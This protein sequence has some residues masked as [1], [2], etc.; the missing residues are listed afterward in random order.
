MKILNFGSCNIDLVY[1]VDHIALPGET[2]GSSS[3]ELFPGGKG[4]NQSIAAAR[5]GANIY[6]AG[7]IGN[8][9][10]MLRQVFEENNV[11]ISFLKTLDAKTG[12][13]MIQLD[14]NAENS[15]V[16]YGGTNK[17]ISRELVDE[18]IDSF[19]EGDIILLQNELNELEYIIDKA[20]GKGMRIVLNPAP[21][22][23][24]LKNLPLHKI[25]WLILNEIEAKEF[26]NKE[27]PEEN[28]VHLKECYPDTEIIIT[29]GKKGSMYMDNGEIYRQMSYKVESVDTTAAGDTFIGYFITNIANGKD[30]KEALKMSSVASALTV[31]RKGASSSIPYIGEVME[32]QNKLSENK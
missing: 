7:C 21:F 5:A 17:M 10:S 13:A 14:K 20:Y 31:S 2:I 32:M 15:I 9:G 16:L 1:S 23:N 30:V 26:G 24:D 18:V 29:V 8:D 4:L 25:S 27:S 12:H 11:N 28:L 22:T 6:H 19:N 3:L